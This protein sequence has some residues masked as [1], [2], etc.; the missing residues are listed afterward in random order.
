MAKHNN[1]CEYYTPAVHVLGGVAYLSVVSVSKGFLF[2]WGGSWSAEVCFPAAG[3][4]PSVT[5]SPEPV[6]WSLGP[7]YKYITRYSVIHMITMNQS[8]DHQNQ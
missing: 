3:S 6:T 4:V 5:W 8:H 7:V 1:Q 2:F